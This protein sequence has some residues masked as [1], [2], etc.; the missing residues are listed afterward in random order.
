[1]DVHGHP[2][3]QAKP[4]KH[5]TTCHCQILTLKTN[6]FKPKAFINPEIN[7]LSFYGKLKSNFKI[8]SMAGSVNST[9]FIFQQ[10]PPKEKKYLE[11]SSSSVPVMHTV[12]MYTIHAYV[13]IHYI[14]LHY[15]T[16]HYIPFHSIP[17]HYI[18]LHYITLH[19]YIY[20]YIHIIYYII[21]Y[22][23]IYVHILYTYFT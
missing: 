6:T 7:N 17:L 18:T 21:I 9:Y 16:S 23:Y 11:T 1:M 15:I 3:T 19:T 2:W 13:Y 4:S 14:T 8:K 10:S 12:Y 5:L 20:I 22:I